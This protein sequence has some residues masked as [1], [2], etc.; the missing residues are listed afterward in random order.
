MLPLHD[1][2]SD[3]VSVTQT[4]RGTSDE[5]RLRQRGSGEKRQFSCY[6]SDQFTAQ[7]RVDHVIWQ[8]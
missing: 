7:F 8:G 1:V 6:V 4:S 5:N 2:A 3:V